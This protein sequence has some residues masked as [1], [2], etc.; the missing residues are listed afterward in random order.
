MNNLFIFYAFCANFCKESAILNNE[1]LEVSMNEVTPQ[2]EIDK[3]EATFTN[4]EI[5]ERLLKD[6]YMFS[7]TTK[8]FYFIL[9][10]LIFKKKTYGL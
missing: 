1:V 7:M 2:N 3:S 5:N 10:K 9:E 6:L 8:C 4:T